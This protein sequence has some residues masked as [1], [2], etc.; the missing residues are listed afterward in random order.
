[1]WGVLA[2]A[3]EVWTFESPGG[4]QVP[5]FGSVGLR[6]TLG[7]SG[8]ATVG[9]C[10]W[11]SLWILPSPIPKLQ[12][13]PLPLKVLWAK[14]HIPTPASYAVF[15]LDSHLSPSRCWECIN[16]E[17]AMGLGMLPRLGKQHLSHCLVARSEFGGRGSSLSWSSSCVAC[18]SSSA[19]LSCGGEVFPLRL[20][21][22]SSF[23]G[24][25]APSQTNRCRRKVWLAGEGRDSFRRYLMGAKAVSA[26]DRALQNPW[27]DF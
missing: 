14:E 27:C 17:L 15:H 12:H 10:E 20:P 19:L 2:P 13:A 22:N 4:L 5:N 7:Q 21:G 8:V 16:N 25:R 26:F 24:L 6:P 18:L 3:I 11:I 1:M 23:R 9:P